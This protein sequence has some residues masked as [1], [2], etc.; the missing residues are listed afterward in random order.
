M[1]YAKAYMALVRKASGREVTGYTESHHIIP[2]CLGG[3]DAESNLV[4]L[5][6]REHY[7]AH[8]LLV[9]MHPDSRGLAFAA[10]M[11]SKKTL[12]GKYASRQY[13]WI[14]KRAIAA[15]VAS[16]TGRPRP[17]SV[18]DKCRAA[19]SGRPKSEAHRAKLSAAQKGKKLSEETR[20]RISAARQGRATPEDVKRKISESLKGRKLNPGNKSKTGQK[21]SPETRAKIVAANTGRKQ[22]EEWK[23]NKANAVR[24]VKDEA[25]AEI[26]SMYATG[27]FS[28]K[29]IAEKMGLGQSHVGRIIRGEYYP[30]AK[31]VSE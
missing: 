24:K 31:E 1:D 14:R 22:S 20:R 15:Q 11:M 17:Q 3:S 10:Y 12:L 9:K 16:Q 29:A 25:V 23:R 26:R 21:L 2:R 28:Q 13:E 7:V 27:N 4:R 8:Q 6:A 5:T 30:A 19:H 18:I